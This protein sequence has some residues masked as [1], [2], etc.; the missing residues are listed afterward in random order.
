MFVCSLNLRAPLKTLKKDKLVLL[1]SI[2]Y[3]VTDEQKA[4]AVKDGY[5]AGFAGNN[6][7]PP[8]SY[9][10]NTTLLVCWY[11]GYN[12]GKRDKTGD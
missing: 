10:V 3:L 6:T 4:M 7:E 9:S 11:W 8:Q 5:M 2:H 12:Q 1:M